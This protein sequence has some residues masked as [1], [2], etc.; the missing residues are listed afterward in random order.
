MDSRLKVFVYR[1]ELDKRQAF[2]QGRKGILCLGLLILDCSSVGK[3]GR[4]QKA[5]K[6]PAPKT[7]LFFHPEAGEAMVF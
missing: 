5:L 4:A 6:G 1:K 7:T 2:S 3:A